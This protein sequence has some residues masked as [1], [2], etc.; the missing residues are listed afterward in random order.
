MENAASWTSTVVKTIEKKGKQVLP[1][2]FFPPSSCS[3]LPPY[4]VHVLKK[5][6]LIRCA[7]SDKADG[8]AAFF[9]FS[10]LLFCHS[11]ALKIPSLN[12][13]QKVQVQKREKKYF[14]KEM[15]FSSSLSRSS[16]L[17]SEEKQGDADGIETKV[18]YAK[19]RK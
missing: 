16:S 4:L 17:W 9:L 7:N 8:S 11:V 14:P 18:W 2:S 19:K 12:C 13:F 3:A 10:F 5:Y 15:I 1:P 6:L